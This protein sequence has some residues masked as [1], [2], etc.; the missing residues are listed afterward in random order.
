MRC[1]I[2]AQNRHCIVAHGLLAVGS[3]PARSEPE[4]PHELK[5]TGISAGVEAGV[6]QGK[7]ARGVHLSAYPTRTALALTIFENDQIARAK[8]DE[9]LSPDEWTKLKETTVSD[10]W[11]C[12]IIY[13]E[14]AAIISMFVNTPFGDISSAGKETICQWLNRKRWGLM[15][16]N[17]V[18]GCLLR[19]STIPVRKLID[20]CVATL[21]FRHEQK[22]ECLRAR[23]VE[24]KY[25]TRASN[26]HTRDYWLSRLDILSDKITASQFAKAVA[27]PSRT[28]YYTP[29]LPETTAGSKKQAS[30]PRI[31][32]SR[33]H[34]DVW[35]ATSPI[36]PVKPGPFQPPGDLEPAAGGVVRTKVS[37]SRILNVRG[38]PSLGS[39]V[40]RPEE[41]I[42][43]QGALP[44]ASSQVYRRTPGWFR[45]ILAFYDAPSV[46]T[47]NMNEKLTKLL[48]GDWNK[49]EGMKEA[50]VDACS[51]AYLELGTI[52][53][54]Y[55]H[56]AFGTL[57]ADV[58]EKIF[59]PLVRA[60]LEPAADGWI[61]GCILQYADVPME[62][63]ITFCTDDLD[64]KPFSGMWMLQC[65]MHEVG[66]RSRYRPR[67]CPHPRARLTQLLAGQINKIS[68]PDLIRLLL[69]STG[70]KQTY[71]RKCF[72]M[73]LMMTGPSP[74]KRLSTRKRKMPE[75]K[76]P[77]G[78]MPKRKMP[79]P[80]MPERKVPERKVPER[81]ISEEKIPS[82]TRVQRNVG[83]DPDRV[84]AVTQSRSP[85]S[86]L[87]E[88]SSPE[89]S[90]EVSRWSFK[91]GRDLLQSRAVDEHWQEPIKMKR[92]TC[93]PNERSFGTIGLLAIG[94]GWQPTTL[95]AFSEGLPREVRSTGMCAGIEA[96][97]GQRK[98]ADKRSV[99]L[100]AYRTRTPLALTIFENE[101]VARAKLDELLSPDE[102]TKLKE[103][104]VSDLWECE[105]IY[106]E[107]AAIISMFVNTPF[108]DISS[109]GKETICQWMGG[110][111][112]R[113]T[114]YSW[115]TGC[116]L[117]RSTIPIKKLMDFCVDTLA[118]V[119]T[120]CVGTLECFRDHSASL[121]EYAA[122]A[123]RVSGRS[124]L[125]GLLESLSRKITVKEYAEAIGSKVGRAP[126]L[127]W[128]SMA[129]HS[130]APP[131]S[132]PETEAALIGQSPVFAI[133]PPTT[134]PPTTAPPTSDPEPEAA[135]FR[136]SSGLSIRPKE[137]AAV[138]KGRV[139]RRT[140]GVLSHFGLDILYPNNDVNKKLTKL[141]GGDW[142]KLDEM[143]EA[144]V[145]ACSIAYLELGTIIESYMR[146]GFGTVCADVRDSLDAVLTK[147]GFIN[148]T[149][150]WI[151]GCIL[152][153]FGLQTF[154][155]NVDAPVSNA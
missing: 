121:R 124:Y 134:A 5:S 71:V 56:S 67:H 28:P 103:I 86:S 18:T 20:F 129:S 38:G 17:W 132:G 48:G 73:N 83:R 54:Y 126:Y 39:I 130:I 92:S 44:G 45:P 95:G 31:L 146:D 76:M 11:E 107:L 61:T 89:L 93:A 62:D 110:K 87:V 153:I 27:I 34:E 78:K 50:D 152:Q 128:L 85:L 111:K 154:L 109:A 106:V 35:V 64:Y 138:R 140:P 137:W 19:R 81:K 63:L 79:K 7:D 90:M 26:V 3:Q 149:S 2:C 4:P 12:E 133:T 42:S 125:S 151:T 98:G 97:V 122:R 15:H 102:W 108:G 136:Q 66:R 46:P 57:S 29:A 24:S 101:L 150:G 53:E 47:D 94:E 119:P 32:S 1:L 141:L 40:I 68:V 88:F 105:I 155:G 123:G 16:R 139:Y 21:P 33:K 114:H 74:A 147:A 113:S 116:L 100:S 75:G 127:R 60:G 84:N 59:A 55:M 112:W 6:A 96:C 120:K 104:T 41:C 115:A 144:D 142:N 70:Q 30:F 49:L 37:A 25:W 118:Y 14:L 22:L 23:F 131:I 145:D 51:I 91:N 52:I 9:L 36:R 117:R 77:E 58:R 80:K 143:K 10:L 99:Y 148:V 72:E 82:G 69:G 65:L 13:V 135:S 8:L 43:S